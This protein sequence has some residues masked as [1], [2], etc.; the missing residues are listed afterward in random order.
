MNYEQEQINN[1]F[2]FTGLKDPAYGSILKAFHYLADFNFIR[3]NG[4]PFAYDTKM[5]LN[6]EPDSIHLALNATKL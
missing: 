6:A 3:I 5:W 2:N 4:Y 1:L